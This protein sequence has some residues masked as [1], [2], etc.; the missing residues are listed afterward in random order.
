M[1]GFKFCPECG[2]SVAAAGPVSRGARKVVT[3]LFCDV[4]GSTA[5]GERLDPES[6]LRVMTRYFDAMRLVVE[7]T[8]WNP[9]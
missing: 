7:A 6:L 5:L 1:A 4:A 3:L 2:A 8:W 9:V